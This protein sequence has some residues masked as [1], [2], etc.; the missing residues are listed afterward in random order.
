MGMVMESPTVTIRNEEYY[1]LP[2]AA[3]LTG[4]TDQGLKRRMQRLHMNV[5]TKLPGSN[6]VYV[7]VEDINTLLGK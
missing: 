4:M 7:R 1:A 6:R 3:R 5:D 2:Y